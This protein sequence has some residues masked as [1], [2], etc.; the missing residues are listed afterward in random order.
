[1]HLYFDGNFDVRAGGSLLVHNEFPGFHIARAF[2]FLAGQRSVEIKV[3]AE[4]FGVEFR[5]N[6]GMSVSAWPYS[7]SDPHEGFVTFR[8]PDSNSLEFECGG[9]YTSTASGGAELRH[10]IWTRS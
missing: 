9:T 5:W 10:P 2:G 8:T 4:P 7:D 1:M 6:R 3:S